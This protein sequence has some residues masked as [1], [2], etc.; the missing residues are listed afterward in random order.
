MTE[1]ILVMGAAGRL[2]KP[3]AAAFRDAGWEV[4]SL[5]RPGNGRRAAEQ[6]RVVEVNLRDHAAIVAA[7]KDV[8]VVLNALGPTLLE[9]RQ[10]PLLT[11]A[12]IVAAQSAGATLISPGNV[13]QFGA[14]MPEFLDETTP[15]HPTTQKGV[16]RADAEET[17]RDALSE[18]LPRAIILRSGDFFG[19]GSGAW[20]DRVVTRAL[21]QRRV[22]YPGPL[23]AIHPW[24]YVPDFAA[25]IVRLAQ[26]RDTLPP[27]ATFGF[28]GHTLT[29]Q[30][31][32]RVLAKVVQRTLTVERMPWMMLRLLSPVVPTFRAL[33]E[34][35]YLWKVPHRIDGTA[36]R[37]AIGEIPETPLDLALARSLVE[38]GYIV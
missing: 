32:T 9:W 7:A 17:M 35:S 19:G 26:V 22:I 38:L 14:N 37:E 31:L 13:Y 16:L 30:Q 5:V 3:S 2:G 25:T 15:V 6:T 34:M 24:A 29:G 10:M 27:F 36:L 28:P 4:V 33:T 12:A 8:Q 21:A 20:F 23:D 11:N 18:G 1:R